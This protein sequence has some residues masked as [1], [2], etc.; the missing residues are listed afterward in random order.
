MEKWAKK[1]NRSRTLL[2]CLSFPHGCAHCTPLRKARSERVVLTGLRDCQRSARPQE[3]RPTTV[4]TAV[5][6]ARTVWN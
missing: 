1:L 6:A 3:L 4:T 5:L 2:L